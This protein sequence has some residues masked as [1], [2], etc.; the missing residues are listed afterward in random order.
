MS[1]PGKYHHAQQTAAAQAVHELRELADQ[2]DVLAVA[3]IRNIGL[4]VADTLATID[5]LGVPQKSIRW[6]VALDAVKEIRATQI[7]SFEELEVGKKQGTKLEGKRRGFSHGSQTGFAYELKKEIDTAR[8]R[9]A[10]ILDYLTKHPD[11]ETSWR[12]MAARLPDLTKESLADWTAAALELCREY[13][14]GDWS[15][16][17]L[18]DCV[19]S[20]AGKDTDGNGSLRKIESAMYGKISEGL[21]KLIP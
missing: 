16:F 21:A 5:A 6:P 1:I 13:C 4:M 12:E 18:P 10:E 7:T 15:L 9:R 8:G 11:T 14:M 19:D 2:G 20:K 3:A 17:P